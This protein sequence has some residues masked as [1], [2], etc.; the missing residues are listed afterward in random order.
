MS[1][2][3]KIEILKGSSEMQRK[4][5]VEREVGQS[6]HAGSSEDNAG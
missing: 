1:E 3:L 6:Q 5:G 4:G 2:P